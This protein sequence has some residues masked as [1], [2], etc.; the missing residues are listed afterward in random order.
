MIVGSDSQV[1]F[2]PLPIGDPT[3]MKGIEF[4]TVG[5]HDAGFAKRQARSE[6]LKCHDRLVIRVR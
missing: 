4:V 5:S 1:V 6:G 2:R 3:K